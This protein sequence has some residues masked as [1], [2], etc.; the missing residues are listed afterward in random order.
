MIGEYAYTSV[1]ESAQQRELSVL[2]NEGLD[3]EPRDWSCEEDHGD[4]RL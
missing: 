3:N 1:V 4:G 2:T